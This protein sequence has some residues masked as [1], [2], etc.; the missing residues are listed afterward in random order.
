MAKLKNKTLNR[1]KILQECEQLAKIKNILNTTY[2]G[3]SQ[4]TRKN[5]ERICDNINNF[6]DSMITS[7]YINKH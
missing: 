5:Q 1:K 2:S 6:I 7:L 4:Q 3:N